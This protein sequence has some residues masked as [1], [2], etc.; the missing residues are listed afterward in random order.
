MLTNSSHVLD[1]T[2][3]LAVTYP[4]KSQ[5]GLPFRCPYR[6]VDFAAFNRAQDNHLSKATKLGLRSTSSNAIKVLTRVIF[7]EKWSCPLAVYGY[8]NAHMTPTTMVCQ[9]KY[10]IH[11]ISKHLVTFF[12]YLNK[13]KVVSWVQATQNLSNQRLNNL[14]FLGHDVQCHNREFLLSLSFISALSCSSPSSAFPSIL[15]RLCLS[16]TFFSSC[17]TP[18]LLCLLWLALVP[19][20]YVHDV[21]FDIFHV[22]R[23]V[24][25]AL[26]VYD[27]LS[28][29][30]LALRRYP[31]D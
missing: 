31:L 23:R 8:G 6:K 7:I 3:L 16:L 10:K 27:S 17:F 30:R 4:S 19:P 26:F 14:F 11:Q 22:N 5:A 1:S 29:P 28:F 18:T 12:S 20:F 9:C 24:E 15:H 25:P 13:N 2:S 21:V